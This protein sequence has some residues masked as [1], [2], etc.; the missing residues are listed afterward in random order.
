MNFKAI[1]EIQDTMKNNINL[2][3][4]AIASTLFQLPSSAA[5]ASENTASE[6][7]NLLVVMA[8]QFRGDAFGF[9]GKEVVKTPNFDLPKP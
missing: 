9:R 5:A 7:P 4:T 2:Y 3:F 1:I 8:D 6:R